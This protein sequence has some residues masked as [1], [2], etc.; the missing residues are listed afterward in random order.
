MTTSNGTSMTITRCWEQVGSTA[1]GT[2]YVTDE[3][4][5]LEESAYRE[6]VRERMQGLW[7]SAMDLWRLRQEGK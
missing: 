4:L 6:L 7:E 1:C 5:K 2:V 3:E